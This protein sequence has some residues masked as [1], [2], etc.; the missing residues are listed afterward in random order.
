MG[1]HPYFHRFL[2]LLALTLVLSMPA[3]GK[4]IIGEHLYETLLETPHPYP[5]AAEGAPVVVWED[6]FEYP[7]AAYLVFEFS[8]FELEPGDW[9][10]ITTPE[11]RVIQRLEGRGFKNKGGDFISKLVPGGEAFISLYSTHPKPRAFG[12][13]IGRISRGFSEV[14]LAQRKDRAICGTDDKQDAICYQ[15]SFPAIYRKSRAVCRIVMD[16][17][18]LCTGW[19]V[20]CENH[21]LTNNH[22]TWDDSDFDTQAELDRMEFQF[23][24]QDATCG[25]GSPTWEYSFQGGTWLDNHQNLDYTLIQAPAGEDPAST[26]GYLNLDCRLVPVNEQIYIPGH[27][28]GRPKEIAVQSTHAQD[29]SGFAEVYSQTEPA[30]IGGTVG[31]IGYYADTEGGNSGS[32]VLSRV[33]NKVVAL[34]HCADCPNRGVRIQNVYDEIQAGPAPLPDCT[35][36]GQHGSLALDRELYGCSTAI[37]IKVRDENL[38]GAGTVS[39][40]LWSTT[41]PAPESVTLTENA[42]LP[43][44]FAGTSSTSETTPVHG[45]GLLS[46]HHGDTITARYI[47]ANDGH[48]GTNVN[49]DDTAVGACAPPSISGVSA[50]SITTSGATIGWTTNLPANGEVQYWEYPTGTPATVAIGTQTTAHSVTLGGLLD[51]TRYDFLVRSTDTAGNTAQDDNGGAGYS[52]WTGRK[53]VSFFDNMEGGVNGWTHSAATGTDDWQQLTSASHSATHSWWAS[54]PS[55]LKDDT[56]VSPAIDIDST[57]T[58]S[59]WHKYDLESGFDGGVIEISTNGGS[60]WADLG[61]AITLHPYTSTLST[62][63][64]NPIG[65]RMAWSGAA[66]WQEVTAN[67]SSYGPN[68][69]RLRFRIGCDTSVG[70][71]GWWVD[72]VDVSHAE[73][74]GPVA[75]DVDGDGGFDSDDVSLLAAYLAGNGVVLVNPGEADQDGSGTLDARDLHLLLRLLV[76]L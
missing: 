28:S 5:G 37:G 44:Y 17:D 50:T 65:G 14:E 33:T 46:I 48:G 38:E 25:G 39:I 73:P 74:C 67:L 9:V 26:Y 61:P 42:I 56:L 31:E 35:L 43:G 4:E 49:R 41:E 59:F 69:I 66:D 23:M 54:D 11:G 1:I 72:D 47:D 58:L 71:T 34:H 64:S 15:S 20:S 57:C 76:S 70:K 60:T 63:Y 8:R 18:A 7:Q 29:Q 32:P 13:E 3:S 21:L 51:C 27:P 30:C 22:C 53:V 19:L 75:G 62:S 16:G 40:S 68:T 55:A 6:F 12:Y 2:F 45:D 52:F 36:Y 24:Y 10:E